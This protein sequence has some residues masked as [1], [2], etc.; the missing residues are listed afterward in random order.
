MATIS[1]MGATKCPRPVR[2]ALAASFVACAVAAGCG[3]GKPYIDTSLSEATVTGTVTAGSSPVT[4]GGKIHF[5]ASNSG[6][7]VE[8]RGADIGPDGKYSVKTFTGDNV[9][10]Y[11]GAVAQKHRGLAL[12]KDYVTVQSGENHLDFDILGE[13]KTPGIDFSKTPNTPKRKR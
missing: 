10:T 11:T 3:D 2:L 4:E 1:S 8:T 9:V 5:N 7:H 13:R 12:R 6:R